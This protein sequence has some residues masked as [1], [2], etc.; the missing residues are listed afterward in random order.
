MLIIPGSRHAIPTAYTCRAV[1]V[2][3]S[4]VVSEPE[5]VSDA[6][7]MEHSTTVRVRIERARTAQPGMMTCPVAYAPAPAHVLRP[8]EQPAS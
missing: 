7:G 3:R 5:L 4:T 1:L 6:P 8:P 2:W